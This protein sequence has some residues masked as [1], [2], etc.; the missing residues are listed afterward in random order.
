MGYLEAG[1]ADSVAVADADLVVTE[2]F[3]SE[4]LA[5][6]PV[7]E[8]VAS[9]LAF[10]VPIRVDLVDE[11]C[12]L[13]AAVPTEIALTVALDVELPDTAR[14]LHRVLEHASEDGLALPGH[15]LRHADV[16]RQQG[17]QGASAGLSWFVL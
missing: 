12:T 17:A 7:D 3:D 13:L 2:A 1:G 16:D 8:I 15:I 14:T 11:H 5:E 9:E 10:P 6:L 4:V